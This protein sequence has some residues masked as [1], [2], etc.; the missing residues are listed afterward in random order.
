MSQE[1]GG[2]RKRRKILFFVIFLYLFLSPFTDF[3]ILACNTN[4][5]LS[6]KGILTYTCEEKA[7]CVKQ[8]KTWVAIWAFEIVCQ[9]N[10]DLTI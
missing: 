3:Q 2:D 9:K 7:I 8:L 4:I 1:V 6:F 10:K 5:P